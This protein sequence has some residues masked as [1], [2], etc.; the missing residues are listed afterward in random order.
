MKMIEAAYYNENDPYCFAWLE[1]LIKRKLIEPGDVDGRSIQDVPPCD[2]LPYRQAHFFAGIGV[3]SY[4]CKQVKALREVSRVW[5]GSCPCQP[6]SLAGKGAG[7]DD[8]RHLWPDWFWL[9]E[10]CRPQL[11]FG[12][13]VASNYTESWI[14]LVQSDLEGKAYT[15]GSN[16]LPACGFGAPHERQRLWW[17]AY[18]K[19]TQWKWPKME[20]TA[21]QHSRS[22][23]ALRTYTWPQGCGPASNVC[24]SELLQK[25]DGVARQL[26]QRRTSAYGNAI[27]APVA[28]EFIRAALACRP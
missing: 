10:Q 26:E 17:V 28:V 27:V 12:E 20:T 15:T 18:A 8:E 13:Q 4:A 25:V 14:N 11:I 22:G 23:K 21:V 16:H 2:V 5:T 9:I 19:G 24:V 1:N 6:F 3:W 7:F